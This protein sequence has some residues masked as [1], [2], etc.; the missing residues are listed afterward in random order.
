MLFHVVQV[1][2]ELIKPPSS[3]WSQLFGGDAT[4]GRLH[5]TAA[6]FREL[7]PEHTM[8]VFVC[9]LCKQL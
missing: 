3:K 9:C 6:E 4:L 2:R 7:V 5:I 1:I 8:Q